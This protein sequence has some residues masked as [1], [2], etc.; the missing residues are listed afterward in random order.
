VIQNS[1]IT[2]VVVTHDRAESVTKTIQSIHN[3]FSHAELILIDT[4]SKKISK[5]LIDLHPNTTY[6]PLSSSFNVLECRNI[7]YKAAKNSIVFFLDDDAFI[8]DK[9]FPG[10]LECIFSK[11]P[12]AAIITCNLIERGKPLFKGKARLCNFFFEGASIVNK[13]KLGSKDLYNPETGMYGENSALSFRIFE[14]NLQILL[15]PQLK[16]IHEPNYS[17]RFTSQHIQRISNNLKSNSLTY[18]SNLPFLDSCFLTLGVY[19]I[20]LLQLFKNP[21]LVFP[22]IIASFKIARYLPSRLLHRRL[23][24]SQARS[25]YYYVSL[26]QPGPSESLP[27]RFTIFD[28]IVGKLKNSNKSL[29][30]WNDREIIT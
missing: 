27:N 14:D 1:N 7:G 20:Y 29:K 16:I 9:L 3:L 28:Y 24:S 18:F 12:R 23:I 19:L 11:Y 10:Y 5:Y 21:L 15:N 6:L 2:F 4:G 25:N 17:D 8:E 22:I 13:D 26:N 30:V